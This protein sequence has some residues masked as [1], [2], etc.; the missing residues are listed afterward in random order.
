MTAVSES[1][2]VAMRAEC[3]Q[4]LQA[5]QAR[6]DQHMVVTMLTIARLLDGQAGDSAAEVV[7]RF[8]AVTDAMRAEITDRAADDSETEVRQFLV[9]VCDEVRVSAEP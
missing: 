7:Q 6:D 3:A 5:A 9:Q 2:L 1:I 8:N 4:M